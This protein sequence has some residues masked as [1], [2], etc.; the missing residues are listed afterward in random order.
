LKLNPFQAKPQTQ[1]LIGVGLRHPHYTSSL[2][3]LPI[4]KHID[5]V[6]IHAENFFAQGGISQTLLADVAAKYKVSVHGTSLGLGSGLPVPHDTLEQ[7]AQVV[8]VSHAFLVSE[9]LC[10]N[11][12]K[13]GDRILHSGDLLPL[14]YNQA[15]LDL[16]T[17]NIEQ[18]QTRLQRPILIENLSAYI[19]AHE[20]DANETDEFSE[21]AFLTALCKQAGCGLLLDLNN[22]IVNALNQKLA[23]PVQNIIDN[24]AQLPSHL[25]GEI[26]LAGFSPKQVQGFIVDD[27]ASAVSAQCWQLY[28]NALARFGNVPTLIEWDNNLPEW[29]V[30][31][32]QADKARALC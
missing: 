24:I 7:F 5:F 12:A 14:A 32:A 6:E 19:Q 23:S 8:D 26:H 25:I 31:V 28:E 18:V 20:I 22:L 17:Q 9:H 29:E 11:R 30:L 15:S 16:L 2:S 27:H 4:N 13:V 10:F 3:D 21:M 1:P